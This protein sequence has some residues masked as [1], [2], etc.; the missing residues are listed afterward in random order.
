MKKK[1]V[2]IIFLLVVSTM[3]IPVGAILPSQADDGQHDSLNLNNF[4]GNS[5][6]ND[7]WPMFHHDLNNTGNSS[8]TAP[9]TNNVLWEYGTGGTVAS[10]PAVVDGKVFFGS[11]D[12]NVYCLD[13]STGA[14]I[15]QYPT[16]DEVWS[17]PAVADGKVFVGSGQIASGSS[18][19]YCLGASTGAWIWN[20]PASGGVDSSPAVAG[21]KVF[22]GSHD[23]N[24]YCLDSSTGAWIWQYPTGGGVYSSPAVTDGKVY[25]GSKDCNLYCLDASTGAWIWNYPTPAGMVT[26]SPA[27]V[28][29][30]VFFGTMQ[31]PSGYV[32]CLNALTGAFIWQHATMGLMVQSS[33]AV[34]DGK[35]FV[36]SFSGNLYCLD[37]SDGHEIW[38]RPAG[39]GG[40]LS[41]P[42]VAD[43][44][45]YFGSYDNNVYCLDA[46]TGAIIWQ[47][48]TADDVG[49]SPA[50]ADGKVFIGSKDCNLYC[51][52]QPD[53]TPPE[54]TD[55]QA[56]PSIQ[57]SGGYVNITATVTD[58]IAVDTVTVN[59]TSPAFPA[60]EMINVPGTDT[61]YYNATYTEVG[62]Y[63]YFIWAD[64][65]SENENTSDTYHFEIMCKIEI[66]IS[67]GLGINAIIRN[68]G[69]EDVTDLEYS[70]V[71]DGGFILLPRGGVAAG[72]IDILAG[73][74]VSIRA[75]VLGLG[76]SEITVTAGCAE[77]TASGL[78]ILLFV[79]GV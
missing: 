72:T 53:T 45:V 77:E 7:W 20:Y 5:L 63:D 78:V 13:A 31:P 46:S 51:F 34:A 8:S 3:I 76:R 59:I 14:W 55:V 25:F 36:G 28:E 15:W 57:T 61:Y 44:K 40:V 16:G 67:G 43:G 6:A 24:L 22:I 39:S 47:H 19:V 27:V 66:E 69:E 41:S 23:G 68:T 79:L 35:V 75:I 56:T 33:P 2:E 11:I 10:S 50:V 52:G 71:L 38:S 1:F 18:N 9:D 73:D 70:I 49:S 4:T 74:E 26:S 37:A 58:D 29:G 21:G 64:D 62:T 32:Y 65:T 48:L 60:E 12:G 17:S 42:A 30:K 54:I